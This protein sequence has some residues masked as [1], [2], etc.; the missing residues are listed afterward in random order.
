MLNFDQ[1]L[2]QSMLLC[3]AYFKKIGTIWVQKITV[4]ILTEN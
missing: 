1:K 4:I 3:G 2:K